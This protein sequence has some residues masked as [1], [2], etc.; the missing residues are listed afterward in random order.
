MVLCYFM[1][2]VKPL[3]N[4]NV[5]EPDRSSMLSTGY[6]FVQEF[7]TKNFIC[8]SCTPAKKIPFSLFCWSMM[9]G[10]FDSVDS[11]QNIHTVQMILILTIFSWTSAS[12]GLMSTS[13][14]SASDQVPHW[15]RL[16]RETESTQIYQGLPSV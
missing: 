9:V 4:N 10:H 8:I 1:L 6:S 13:D 5:F 12:D 3:V 15:T 14:T 11:V 2:G 16:P 7:Y